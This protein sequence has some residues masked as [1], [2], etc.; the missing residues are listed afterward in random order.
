MDDQSQLSPDGLWYWDGQKWLTTLSAN[1]KFRWDG[2]NWVALGAAPV[3]KRPG[4]GIWWIPG[5]RTDAVWKLPVVAGGVLLLPPGINFATS[6]P[7]S[8]SAGQGVA[9]S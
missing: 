4:G 7:S 6:Q 1:G 8:R 5:F 9:R 2:H 3:G